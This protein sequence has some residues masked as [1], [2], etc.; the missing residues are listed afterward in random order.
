MRN[1]QSGNDLF[2][3]LKENR[4]V[5]YG[6]LFAMLVIPQ[7]V[8]VELATVA[9]LV[10]L[11]LYILRLRAK[12]VSGY[13]F[14]ICAMWLIVPESV[15]NVHGT[16]LIGIRWL[17]YFTKFVMF[18]ILL[19][20]YKDNK[21][22]PFNIVPLCIVYVLLYIIY[23]A[24]P[25]MNYF[26]GIVNA[27]FYVHVAF[28]IFYNDKTE[29]ESTGMYIS[30]LFII[31]SLYAIIQYFFKIC[32]YQPLYDVT[33]SEALGYI[34][35]SRAVGLLGN[36]LLLSGLCM[37]YNAI[38]LARYMK[39]GSLNVVMT[40]L[41][42]FVSL[43]TISRTCVVIVAL[44]WIYVFFSRKKR[45]LSGVVTIICA[46]L[47]LIFVVNKV[48]MDSISSLS[49]RFETRS[50]HRES[51]Y[52]TTINIFL[53]NPL[54]VGKQRVAKYMKEFSTGGIEEDL[55]TLDNF[56]LTHIASYGILSFIPFLFY[57]FYFV[58]CPKRLSDK[59]DKHFI[60]ITAL[61]WCLL[62]LSYDVEHFAAPTVFTIL[63]IAKYYSS[64]K[65]ETQWTY[66]S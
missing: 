25:T 36:S 61:T 43:I 48:A 49:E 26:W 58:K 17:G 4:K 47:L 21:K 59:T 41:C 1:I 29:F 14:I 2:G 65:E 28:Y 60:K 35:L 34:H 63:A 30:V 40:C 39:T 27:I 31:T 44:Q 51:G 45:R 53:D 57:L 10:L 13:T 50:Y 16:F 56:Y 52:S 37:V 42:M 24:N 64:L 11:L 20:D 38:I 54:G 5:I 15:T 46:S 9:A 8:R 23:M 7:C 18:I 12:G 3:F 6:I 33:A 62:G 32:P 19:L 66:Q 22:V 55:V